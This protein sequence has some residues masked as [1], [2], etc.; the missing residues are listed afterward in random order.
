[1]IV[2]YIPYK[3]SHEKASSPHI[4]P[5][6]LLSEL[7]NINADVLFINGTLFN[8]IIMTFGVL[9]FKRRFSLYV[10][11]ST[12]PI[13]LN[14]LKGHYGFS[15]FDALNFVL[16]AIKSK[17]A[18]IFVRDVHWMYDDIS[19]LRNKFLKS[20]YKK[21]GV[22]EQIIF[23]RFFDICFLPTL[24]MAERFSVFSRYRLIENLPPG[25]D[26]VEDVDHKNRTTFNSQLNIVYVGGLSEVYNLEPTI[27][28][29][30]RENHDFILCTREMDWE[31]NKETYIPYIDSDNVSIV[32]LSGSDLK[33]LYS[34]ADIAS[35]LLKPINYHTFQAPVKLYEYIAMAK[36]IIAYRNTYFGDY[37]ERYDL[38]WVF[39]FDEN[40]SLR[41]LTKLEYERKVKNVIAHQKEIKWSS[42]A[43]KLKTCLND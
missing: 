36:P 10:E 37:V 24:K 18:G 35:L 33:T 4:R 28:F 30:I 12:A 7:R 41:N 21:I 5:I 20:V 2:F 9:F 15:F 29:S 13:C 1:M 3:V 14:N 42:R 16:L 43:N 22:I 27:E 38:G 26:V 17:R 39:D 11:T 32:H 34:S 8:R 6:K 25:Y 19:F 31:L 23:S 40:V